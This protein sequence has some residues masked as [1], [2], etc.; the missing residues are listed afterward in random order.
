MER[1]LVEQPS[2]GRPLDR[3][4]GRVGL[5]DEAVE[6]QHLLQG[7]VVGFDH[8][9]RVA[10]GQSPVL[11][12]RGG[13]ASQVVQQHL[14]GA[15]RGQ[16]RG[17]GRVEV[18]EHPEA[19]TA[20]GNRAPS[21]FHGPQQ[22]ARRL[23]PGER[24][25]QLGLAGHRVGGHAHRELTGEPADGVGQVHVALQRFAT[26]AL[27]RD[28]Q[29]IGDR[30]L[31]A[32]PGAQGEDESRQQHLLG[33]GAVGVGKRGQD[34]VGD[35][36]VGEGDR[37]PAGGHGVS[38]RV[39]GG[40]PQRTAGGVEGPPPVREFG[41]TSTGT[42]LL[43]QQRGVPPPRRSRPRQLGGSAVPCRR[44]SRVQVGQQ[45]P[46]RHPVHHEVMGE[47]EN[48][49]LGFLGGT[50]HR[51]AQHLPR[52]GVEFT[53]EL[54]GGR[55]QALLGHGGFDELA[56]D[57]LGGHGLGGQHFQLVPVLGQPQPQRGMAVQHRTNPGHQ[58]RQSRGRSRGHGGPLGVSGHHARV[59]VRVEQ[60]PHDGR[61]G[62]R[63]DRVVG[64]RPRPVVQCGHP[65]GERAEIATCQQVAGPELEPGGSQPAAHGDGGDA[66][67]TEGEE[68]VV[69]AD[70]GG[71]E[72]LG[73]RR[74]QQSFPLR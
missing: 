26:V 68:I 45:H 19:E 58:V 21:L 35:V 16:L 71:P 8:G 14:G 67:A 55:G 6:R 18:A 30:C 2:R 4:P 20:V 44:P 56:D 47:D 49:G 65:P 41:T 11:A 40:A 23:A 62:H 9:E 46:P 28:C 61:R 64:H 37:A 13:E 36:R 52:E 72:H 3:E 25:A 74:A 63:A 31:S 60:A 51:D 73:D 15:G 48:P 59:G 33:T 7:L 17:D 70:L 38:G 10:V 32:S 54:R 22:P 57:P 29:R 39:E 53:G 5:V 69:G 43:G 50:D 66:V 27:Q 24:V 1:L 34:R 42:S 12:R